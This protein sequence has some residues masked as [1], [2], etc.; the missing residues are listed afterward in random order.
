MDETSVYKAQLCAQANDAHRRWAEGI[1]SVL[2]N[3]VAARRCIT[4]PISTRRRV[5]K[6]SLGIFVIETT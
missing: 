2:N 6:Y 1:Y 4:D 5:T 3:S